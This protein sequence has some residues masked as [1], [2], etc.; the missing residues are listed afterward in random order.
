[1]HPQSSD[2]KS[3]ALLLSYLTKLCSGWELNPLTF[4]GFHRT[5]VPACSTLHCSYWYGFR[6]CTDLHRFTVIRIYRDCMAITAPF[7]KEVLIAM[8]PSYTL[9]Y[10]QCVT[11]GRAMVWCSQCR[12]ALPCLLHFTLYQIHLVKFYEIK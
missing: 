4:S 11:G 3:E 5:A 6:S 10:R 1:M 7:G 9:I 12:L 8:K 2:Y